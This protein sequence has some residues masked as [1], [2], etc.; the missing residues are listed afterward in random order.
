M[1]RRVHQIFGR[2]M[3]LMITG[4]ANFDSAIG[5]DLYS[6]G[7]RFWKP[8]VSPRRPVR[9]CSLARA[10]AAWARLGIHFRG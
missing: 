4:G 3:R 6:L 5:G 1:F 9:L 2:D 8:M 10:K 7:F